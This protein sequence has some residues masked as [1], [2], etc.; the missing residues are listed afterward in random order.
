MNGPPVP[1]INTIPREGTI[2]KGK[3]SPRMIATTV[4]M[5]KLRPR[6]KRVPGG[7]GYGSVREMVLEG[8]C[9]R[10][11]VLEAEAE[12]EEKTGAWGRE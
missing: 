4:I 8:W 10:R 12:T 5:K 7:G 3:A 2:Q 1:T 6:R 9:V 11:I